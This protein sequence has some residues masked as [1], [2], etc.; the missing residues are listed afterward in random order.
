MSY[1]NSWPEKVTI[2]AFVTK[3]SAFPIS[4]FPC[5]Q[6][7]ISTLE[8]S[9]SFT[10]FW[11]CFIIW[12][13]RSGCWGVTAYHFSF[14]PL[15]ELWTVANFFMVPVPLPLFRFRGFHSSFL[16]TYIS[17]SSLTLSGFPK[18]AHWTSKSQPCP[19]YLHVLHFTGLIIVLVLRILLWNNNLALKSIDEKACA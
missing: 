19:E 5:G 1:S 3:V 2:I 8:V 14:Q 7:F 18:T 11:E 10:V 17:Q 9:A 13:F 6:F 16:S 15:L 12:A 4:P